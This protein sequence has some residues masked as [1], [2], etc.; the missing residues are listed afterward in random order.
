MN[1]VTDMISDI[2]RRASIK[3]MFK[4]N[5]KVNQFLRLVKNNIP[6]QGAGVHKLDCDCGL[7][8]IDQTKRSIGVRVKGHIFDFKNGHVSKSVSL[9]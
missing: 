6:L 2:L 1:W 3:T 5:K 8:Y 4:P 9:L 7:A